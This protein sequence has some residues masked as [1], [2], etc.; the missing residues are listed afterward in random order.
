[1]ATP[2]L[3]I[4]EGSYT[5]DMNSQNNRISKT[6]DDLNADKQSLLELSNK[7]HSSLE[8]NSLLT[9][10]KLDITPILNL[11]D[12]IYQTPGKSDSIDS[13]GRHMVSYQLVLHKKNLGEI[14]LIRRS[15]F[16]DKEQTFIEKVLL[17]LLSPLSNALD[18]QQA[19]NLA[20]QDPLTGVFNR[21]A[22][23]N[24]VSRE[25][26]LSQRNNTPLS[27]LAIDIDFFKKVNDTYGHAFGDCVLKHLTECVKQCTRTTDAMFRYGGEEFNLLLNN[28]AMSGAQELA[29]RI[30]QNIE[31]T[32]C[33]CDGQSINI[34]IS[35]GISILNKHDTQASF[36]KRADD[37]LY[38]AKSAG[39]NRVVT[40]EVQQQAD[41][42]YTHD[43]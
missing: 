29:E 23:D 2:T 36:F 17:A 35:A 28:T 38:Q 42:I 5:V 22:M 1:M 41:K 9:L 27:M 31:Q 3:S 24:M 30:R 37:A 14:A 34:T 10:F 33:I 8:L 11:D 4:V 7:L 13:K 25:I 16:T 43:T 21:F 6:I 12:V 20:S 39:R 19:V 32:P 26:E 18:Y 15:R 40:G